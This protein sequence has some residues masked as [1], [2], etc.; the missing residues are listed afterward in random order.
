MIIK[1]V[2]VV[3]QFLIIVHRDIRFRLFDIF[4]LLLVACDLLFD[5]FDH[6]LVVFNLLLHVFVCDSLSRV[7]S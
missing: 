1:R 3:D 6:S 2:E 5:L 7:S 4:D